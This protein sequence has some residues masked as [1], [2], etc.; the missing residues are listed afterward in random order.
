M[1]DGSGQS[2]N[3]QADQ[4][5]VNQGYNQFHLHHHTSTAQTAAQIQQQAVNKQLQN[6]AQYGPLGPLIA[7]PEGLVQ[8]QNQLDGQIQNLKQGMDL[9]SAPGHST[10]NYMGISH[11]Q[12]YDSV[13][14]VDP[15]TVGDVGSTW[16]KIGNSMAGT[17]D[18][19]AAALTTSQSTWTGPASDKARTSVATLANK[20]GQAGQAAQ[21]AG[22]LTSQQA[23]AARNAKA[24]VPAPPNPAYNPAAAQQQLQTIQDPFALAVQGAAD[25]KAQA[26]QQAAHQEAATAVQ[27]YDTQVQ[28]TSTS[29]PAFAPPPAVTS[30]GPGGTGGT[31]T[32]S[33]GTGAG[34]GGLPTGGGPFVG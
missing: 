8:G 32:G 11:Q 18:T 27:A 19:V 25:Q 28:Q 10:A 14:S 17:L 34:V 21:L 7:L 31:G 22:T 12:L 15:G 2:K 1:A 16:L 30:K 20:S 13:Q 5:A 33:T 23:D 6:S 29:Q 24:S 3:S 26:A 9:R 4:Q